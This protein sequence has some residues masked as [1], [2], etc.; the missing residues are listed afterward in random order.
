M[1]QGE[2]EKVSFQDAFTTR[3]KEYLDDKKEDELIKS[4][5]RE[6]IFQ[7]LYRLEIKIGLVRN[8]NF[9]FFT[10]A[11]SSHIVIGNIEFKTEVN[12]E[13][14]IIEITKIVDGIVTPL[15]TIIVQNG[16]LLALG[17]NEKF[18]TQIFEVYLRETFSEKL[19]LG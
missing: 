6:I 4:G 1:W 5:H 18:T 3:L 17:R 2:F 13:H 10:S 8:P 12:T 9:N 19:G 7:Y 15:D 16:E 11:R 14:N